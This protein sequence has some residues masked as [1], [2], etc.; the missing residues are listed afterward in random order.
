MEIPNLTRIV[1]TYVPIADMDF[2]RYISQ[3]RRDVLVPVRE[4]Q[5]RDL[6]R[7]YSFLVHG[8]D[9]L[10]GREPLDGKAYIHLRLE[11][12]V[13]IDVR[14]FERNL[15]GHF[16]KPIQVILGNIGGL[17]S[18]VLRG[19]DWAYAWKLHGEASEWV[20]CLIESHAEQPIPL[21]QITQFLHYITNPLM[22]GH[23]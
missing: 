15:P 20:L 9:Q 10:S 17:D 22:L 16:C 18:R 2:H 12:R 13:G 1:D 8:P 7:W 14:E 21:Q 11:P 3:L 4:L 19:E 23:R 5:R 6:V